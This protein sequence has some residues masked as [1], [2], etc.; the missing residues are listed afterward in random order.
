MRVEMTKWGDAPHWAFDA[1]YLGS[2]EHGGWLG[3][4]AGTSMARPQMSFTT[5]TAQVGLVPGPAAGG[6]RGWLATFH[7]PGFW[8]STYVDMTSVPAWRD[9]VRGDVLSAIDLDLDVIRLASGDVFVDDEDEFEEHRV[10][11]GYPQE[12][13]DLARTSCTWVH[14]A[15]LHERTPFDGEASRRWF[16]ALAALTDG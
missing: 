4:P 10:V 13:E 15:V 6:G 7:A 3:I 5:E 11:Y 14:D 8:V 9:D 16:A 1:R 12:T 2:D